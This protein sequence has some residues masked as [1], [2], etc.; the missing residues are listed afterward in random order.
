[1]YLSPGICPKKNA[2]KSFFFELIPRKHI[3]TEGNHASTDKKDMSFQTSFKQIL[4]EK[5]S[6]KPYGE[7]LNRCSELHV[8]SSNMAYLLGQIRR[9]ETQTPRRQCYPPPRVRPQRKP[10]SFSESQRISYEFLKS[11][12][13]DLPDGFLPGELKKAFRQ[14]AFI[15]HPDHGG[16]AQQFMELKRHYENLRTLVSI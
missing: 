8:D 16:S 6:E 2:K 5:M 13:Q 7:T 4:R 12:I 1:M 10:H 14:A 9:V 11:C 15:H 3:W